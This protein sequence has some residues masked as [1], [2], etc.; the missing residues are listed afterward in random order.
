MFACITVLMYLAV[1]TV[2]VRVFAPEMSSVEISSSYLKFFSKTEFKTTDADALVSPEIT[3]TD[4]KFP[5]APKAV[6]RKIV[7]RAPAVLP[8]AEAKLEVIKVALNELPFSEPVKL[9]AVTMP[10]TLSTNIVALY[11]EFKYKAQIAAKVEDAIS[12]KQAAATDVEPEF[13]EYPKTEEK[14]E[15]VVAVAAASPKNE[16][17]NAESFPQDE[18]NVEKSES[19]NNAP[20]EVSVDELL[21]FDYSK[22]KEDIKKESVPTVSKV[23]TQNVALPQEVSPAQPMTMKVVE[24][25]KTQGTVTTQKTEEKLINNTDKKAGLVPKAKSFESIVTIQATGTNLRKTV[26]EE[27]FEVRFMDDE[28]DIAEDH[29][30]GHV[31]LSQKLAQPKMTRAVT[32]LKR[33]YAPTNTDLIIEKGESEAT[34]PLITEETFNKLLAPYESRGPIG[35]VLVELSEGV[36]AV[37]DVPYSKVMFLDED[38]KETE[39]KNSAYQL[40]VGVKA[41]NALLGYKDGRGEVTTKIIHVHEHELTF[42]TNF[43]QTVEN[44]MVQLLE[45]DLLSKEKTP[46]II[47]S[48]E[49]THFATDK[50]AVKVNDHTFRTNFSKTVL[51][52]RRYLELSHQSEP[53]FVGMKDNTKLEVPSESLMRYVLSRFENSKLGNR[54]LVQV[55]LTK[56]ASRVDVGSQSAGQALATFVQVLDKDGKFYDSVG[57]KSKKVIIVGENQGAT[58]YSMDSKI[59]V[60]VTYEDGTVEFLGSYCSPNTYLVEQL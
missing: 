58:E 56:K 48:E 39:S 15:E 28:G 30:T 13:F 33:G 14:K 9:Q 25:P 57:P 38:M 51:G 23:T 20:E 60:K 5:A 3:F 52:G 54:C 17:L 46:L 29:N 50:K 43:F 53:V 45:E 42:E 55:N 21:A 34:L 40:F 59:N 1:G 6:A 22:A 37:L 4:I 36:E 35:S 10:A 2:A 47:S 41:G 16:E 18:M 27:G 11:K 24:T 44:E 8:K 32:I 7:K 12:T 26:D 19:I 31:T 49:V